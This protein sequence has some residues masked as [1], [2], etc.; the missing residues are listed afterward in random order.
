MIDFGLLASMIAAVA[1]P[2]LVARWWWPPRTL[3][4]TGGGDASG[5]GAQPPSILDA[6]IGPAVLGLI[7]G[8]LVAVALDAPGSFARFGDLVVIRSGVEFWP[9]VAAAIAAIAWSAHREGVHPLARLADLAPLAMLGYAA[10]EAGCVVR[11]GCFGPVGPVGLRPPGL[12]TTMVPVGWLVAAVVGLA[13]VVVRRMIVADRPPGLVLAAAVTSVA[14]ARAVASF[15]LPHVGDGLTRPHQTS[16]V[17]AVVGAV[18]MA[19]A[20][21]RPKPGGAVG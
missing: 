9:G 4:A 5:G 6:A 12:T 21:R 8:R 10:Y 16:I 14:T 15:W 2:A 3:A 7:V 18:A 1:I 13:A 19:V 17:L 11:D 20:A